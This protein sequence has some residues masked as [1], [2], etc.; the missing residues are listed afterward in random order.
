MRGALPGGLDI[1]G[2]VYELAAGDGR[3]SM[4]VISRTLSLPGTLGRVCPRLC[5][6][7]CRRCDHDEGL[8]IAALHRYSAD[9]NREA[10]RPFSPAPA[11]ASGKTVGI[12]GAGPAGLTAAFYLL[13]A[14]HAC[15]LY[16][17]QSLPG[18][19]LRWGIPDYRLPAD[20]L[21]AEI[22]TIE[23]LEPSSG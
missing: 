15:T 17:A 5:E 11:T 10:P 6:Q 23:A 18:G 13:Q 20:A 3:R 12:V 8:A 9:R 22:A 1:P 16:D 2:F 4:E 19:M 21:D 14:G 7:H